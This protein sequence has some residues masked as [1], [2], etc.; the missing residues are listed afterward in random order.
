MKPLTDPQ[1]RVLVRMDGEHVVSGD[2]H[3]FAD[4]YEIMKSG[5]VGYDGNLYFITAKGRAAL[6]G[7]DGGN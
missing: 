5:L 1:R 3:D 4:M 2:G 6:E 7:G